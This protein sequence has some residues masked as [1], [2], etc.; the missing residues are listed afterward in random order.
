MK[1]KKPILKK[2]YIKL[3]VQVNELDNVRSDYPTEFVMIPENG[4]TYGSIGPDPITTDLVSI[5]LMSTRLQ[6]W[7]SI[8]SNCRIVSDLL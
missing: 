5:H 2:L 8:L 7:N 3:R 4:I 1:G 6:H